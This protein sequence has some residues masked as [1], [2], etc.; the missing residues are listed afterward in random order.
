MAAVGHPA[1]EEGF[2]AMM[3]PVRHYAKVVLIG[4]SNVGKSSIVQSAVAG[5]FD[6]KI[7]PTAGVAY[8]TMSVEVN[9]TPVTL[10]IWDTAGQERYR[11]MI[12]MYY[13]KAHVALVVYSLTDLN[14]FEAIDDW[15]NTLRQHADPDTAVFIVGNKMDL[16]SER[17]V[18]TAMGA[19]KAQQINAKFAEVSALTGRG[20][21]DLFEEIPT[22]YLERATENENLIVEVSGSP[23]KKQKKKGC[24]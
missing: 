20:I 16:E 18:A 23:E 17:V 12:P 10:R 2:R 3:K 8:S 15:L 5:S 9:S 4:N 13:H 24:C 7:A 19:Q 22:V 21:N 6:A 11:A 1:C 14:S